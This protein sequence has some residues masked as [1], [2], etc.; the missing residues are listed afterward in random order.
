MLSIHQF[1]NACVDFFNDSLQK[2]LEHNLSL[3]QLGQNL[4]QF[5]HLHQFVRQ[6]NVLWVKKH[7]QII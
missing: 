2:V 6:A 3:A 7:F 4:N 5:L 1:P